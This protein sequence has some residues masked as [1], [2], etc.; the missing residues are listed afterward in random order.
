MCTEDVGLACNFME[1]HARPTSLSFL[2]FCMSVQKQ[3]LLALSPT[4]PKMSQGSSNIVEASSTVLF[5]V[6]RAA[7]VAEQGDLVTLWERIIS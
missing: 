3:Y 2:V 7:P 1:L 4:F 6:E 5:S